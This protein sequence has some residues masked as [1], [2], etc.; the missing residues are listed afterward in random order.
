MLEIKGLTV[1]YGAIRA[2]NDL[3]LQAPSGTTTAILGANGAGKSS[4]L[5]AISGIS[6]AKGQVLLEG[7]D[8]AS[9]PPHLR[10]RLGI[11]HA[12]EGRRLF[13]DLTV[14]TN[15][16]LAWSFGR[17]VTPYETALARTYERFP[18][19]HERRAT[20]AGWLSG[21]QQQMVILSAAMIQ[22]PLYLL[23]DEPSLGLAP[24]VVK[25]IYDTLSE[26]AA[27]SRITILLAEQIVGIA[28]K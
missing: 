10:S 21:G 9:V 5:R 1:S 12:L 14:E 26:Y 6:L 28:L 27:A 24:I 3:S 17:R 4:L 16:R 22:D 7:R 13:R 8:I 18:I 19:L 25:Q 20:A 23:L 11:A 2:V 15:L